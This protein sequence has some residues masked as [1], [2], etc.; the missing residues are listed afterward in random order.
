MVPVEISGPLW[1]WARM[2]RGT[3][4]FGTLFEVEFAGV[5]HVGGLEGQNVGLAELHGVRRSIGAAGQG[6]GESLGL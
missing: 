4:G 2:A 1:G 5:N 6:L 3:V